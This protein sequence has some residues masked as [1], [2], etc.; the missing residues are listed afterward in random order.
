MRKLGKPRSITT[1]GLERRCQPSCSG[2]VPLRSNPNDRAHAVPP[3]KGVLICVDKFKL[4]SGSR[5]FDSVPLNYSSRLRTVAERLL[6]PCFTHPVP[7]SIAHFRT[8]RNISIPAWHSRS[9]M[10]SSALHLATLH[11]FQQGLF[12]PSKGYEASV[13]CHNHVGIKVSVREDRLVK[14]PRIS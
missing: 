10:T 6:S 8:G 1:C 9:G 12:L 5:A 14:C 7:V 4:T 11:R 2:L 3:R 13:R